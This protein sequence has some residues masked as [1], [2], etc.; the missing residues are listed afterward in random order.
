MP[1]RR[2]LDLH[3]LAVL[4]EQRPL[5][6][7]YHATGVFMRVMDSDIKLWERL[8]QPPRF[9]VLQDSNFGV[10]IEEVR[11]TAKIH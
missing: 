3:E 10:Y 5:W 2:K 4:Y 6:R 9:Q 7:V 11:E 1:E 8:P